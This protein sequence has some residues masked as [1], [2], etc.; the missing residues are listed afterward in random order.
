V[1]KEPRHQRHRAESD[2]ER[3]DREGTV[4]RRGDVVALAQR[5]DGAQNEGYCDES[6]CREEAWATEPREGGHRSEG[7]A[8]LA[9]NFEGH[10]AST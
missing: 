5:P 2:E 3:R 8:F 1:Q 6:Q 9:L 7:Q 4:T 10:L